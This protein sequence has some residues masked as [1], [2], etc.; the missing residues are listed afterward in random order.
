M[1]VDYT[2]STNKTDHIMLEH[3]AITARFLLSSS[4]DKPL[5]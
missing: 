5:M 4:T 3:A 2:V 1:L